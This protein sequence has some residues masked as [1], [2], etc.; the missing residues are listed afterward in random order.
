[1]DLKN[2]TLGRGR[3]F[4]DAFA[5]GTK[6]TTGERYLGNTPAFNFASESEELEHYDSDDGIRVKD[7]S[8]ILQLD[9]SASFTTDN[10]SA[11]NLSLWLLGDQN[12]LVQA[13][14]PGSTSTLTGVKKSHYYQLGRTTGNPAGVREISNVSVTDDDP[15]PNVISTD[16]YTV[17][18][19]LGRV[20]IK[21]D[22]PDIVD[23]TTNLIVTYD[24][25]AS[26][27]SQI[28]TASTGLLEGAMRFIS[29]NPKGTQRDY[30]MPYVQI[31]PDGDFALK[32]DDWQQ[33]SF[34]VEIL[35]LDD[36]T[37]ALYADGRAVVTP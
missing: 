14:A 12:A 27:R 8:V 22:A 11:E 32:G 5:A 19:T 4:F 30:F 31:R 16:N 15:T 21:D 7:D 9:R 10:V 3:V 13:A 24:V 20:Y 33:I 28:I 2:Y 23:G 6:T 18:L 37:E 35:K 25:A 34:N 1:M 17:D 29:T 36:T 26:T